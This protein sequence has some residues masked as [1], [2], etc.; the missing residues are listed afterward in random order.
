MNS[1]EAENGTTFYSRKS[2]E[3]SKKRLACISVE[4]SRQKKSKMSGTI[5][6]TGMIPS[7]VTCFAVTSLELRHVFL[8]KEAQLLR[9]RHESFFFHCQKRKRPNYLPLNKLINNFS[10]QNRGN[11]N[12]KNA[13]LQ[14][15]TPEKKVC[16]LL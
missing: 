8:F 5:F 10:L 3:R 11:K 12:V 1:T 9:I 13:I 6:F 14:L 2:R 16:Y 7:D 4:I 15:V